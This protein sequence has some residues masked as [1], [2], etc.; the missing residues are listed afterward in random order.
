MR[1][2]GGHIPPRHRCNGNILPEYNY[3]RRSYTLDQSQNSV[4]NGNSID[5]PGIGSEIEDQTN[6]EEHGDRNQK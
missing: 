1:S 6:G 4:R 5:H 2:E 3:G